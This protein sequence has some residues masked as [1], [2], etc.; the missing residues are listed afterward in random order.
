MKTHAMRAVLAAMAVLW[1]TMSAPAQETVASDPDQRESLELTVYARDLALVREVRRIAV[2]EGD[3]QLEFR[4]VPERIQPATLLVGG[5]R[6]LVVLEQNYEF[7]LMSRA[8]ILEKYVGREVAWILE[9]GGRVTGRLL[10]TSQGPVFEVNGEIM[11]DMPGRIV[12]PSLPDNLRARPTLVWRVQRPKAGEPDLDVSYLTGGMSWNADYVLQLD[13]AGEQADLRG[14]VTVENRSGA[15]FADATLQL[16]AGD[17]QQVRPALRERVVMDM[18]MAKSAGQAPEMESESLYDYH[19]Y[20][21]PWTTDLPNNSSKQVSMLSA[22]GLDVER[23][24]TVRG[25]RQFFRGGTPDQ[26]QDVWV[27]YAFENRE[28]NQLGKPLPAG[29]VRVYGKASDGRQQLL[30][31]DRIRHTPKDER[32]ELTVGKA[33]DVVAER[34]RMDYERVSDRVHRTTWR[35][36]LRNHKDDDVTVAVR[37]PVGGDW[38][39]TQ[40]SH[41]YEK[42]SAEELVFRLPVAADGETTLTYTVEVRY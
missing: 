38:R 22:S 41:R 3:F 18:A 31:E 33:F 1:L 13:P 6:D 42:V 4:G 32:V 16:V 25:A 40:S 37:E 39:V 14:W 30:G 17:I 28:S 23:I 24:Y 5:D 9:D 27:S 20:T 19:L 11:F 26:R 29:T 8:S 34:T 21:V 2:P 12:L 10:A 36:V 35:V 15:G 7:D